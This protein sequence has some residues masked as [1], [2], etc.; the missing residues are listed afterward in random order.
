MR[1]GKVENFSLIMS[2]LKNEKKFIWW[3]KDN[4]INFIMSYIIQNKTKLAV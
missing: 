3:N 2:N 4:A 1:A